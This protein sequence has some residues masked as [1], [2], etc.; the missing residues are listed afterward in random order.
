MPNNKNQQ[1]IGTAANVIDDSDFIKNNIKN[2]D[3]YKDIVNFCKEN[4]IDLDKYKLNPDEN[5]LSVLTRF[6]RDPSLLKEAAY[7][8]SINDI[9]KDIIDKSF[10]SDEQ[11]LLGI[12][13]DDANDDLYTDLDSL[14][15]FVNTISNNDLDSLID[16]IYSQSVFEKERDTLVE[17]INGLDKYEGKYIIS[18]TEVS[19][20]T[21]SE[22]IHNDD[23]RDKVLDGDLNVK[24]GLSAEIGTD[25]TDKTVVIIKDQDGNEVISL[26]TSLD[27]LKD[28]SDF[29]EAIEKSKSEMEPGF[30]KLQEYIKSTD[31]NEKYHELNDKIEKTDPIIID[32]SKDFDKLIDKAKTKAN[33]IEETSNVA[34]NYSH[35]YH[36]NVFAQTAKLLGMITAKNEGMK[37][38]GKYVTAGEMFA[39]GYR[40]ISGFTLGNIVYSALEIA[41]YKYVDKVENRQ[42]LEQYHKNGYVEKKENDKIDQGVTN[43]HVNQEV[44][45]DATKDVSKDVSND[46]NKS[47][48]EK[49]SDTLSSDDKSDI[50]FELKQTDGKTFTIDESTVL[51]SRDGENGYKE[52]FF[53]NDAKGENVS[54]SFFDKDNNLLGKSLFYTNKDGVTNSNIITDKA[55]HVINDGKI[56]VSIF[57]RVENKPATAGF[58]VYDIKNDKYE[59]RDCRFDHY[60]GDNIEIKNFVP[61]INNVDNDTR[62]AL[63]KDYVLP[64]IEIKQSDVEKKIDEISNQ[65]NILEKIQPDDRE[66]GIVDAAIKEKNTD[67]Q[68]LRNSVDINFSNN[69]KL[70]D[71]IDNNIKSHAIINK[72]SKTDFEKNNSDKLKGFEIETIKEKLAVRQKDDKVDFNLANQ[73]ID[74]SSLSDKEKDILKNSIESDI[75]NTDHNIDTNLSN[76]DDSKKE[77]ISEIIADIY[78]TKIDKEEGYESELVEAAKDKVTYESSS[79]ETSEVEITEEPDQIENIQLPPGDGISL[80]DEDK[81]K[82]S[83]ITEKISSDE[84]FDI[85]S[86]IPDSLT[87]LY[88]DYCVDND[89]DDA[90][91]ETYTSFLESISSGD[92]KVSQDE[93]NDLTNLLERDANINQIETVKSELLQE[94]DLVIDQFINDY[95][96]DN[97]SE[98]PELLDTIAALKSNDEIESI[99]SGIPAEDFISSGMELIPENE[100]KEFDVDGRI[101]QLIDGIGQKIV[102]TF[103]V[104]TESKTNMITGTKDSDERIDK[105]NRI[106]TAL[107]DI[108]KETGCVSKT[109]IIVNQS[110]ENRMENSNIGIDKKELETIKEELSEAFVEVCNE[111]YPEDSPIDQDINDVESITNDFETKA[112]ESIAN[113]FIDIYTGFGKLDSNNDNDAKIKEAITNAFKKCSSS[114]GSYSEN[115]LNFIAQISEVGDKINEITQKDTDILNKIDDISQI[116]VSNIENPVEEFKP[117]EIKEAFDIDFDPI[118]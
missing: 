53:K 76:V 31:F 84:K 42:D 10:N 114:G 40:L 94:N 4:N 38:D 74:L 59:I 23:Y 20:G 49:N 77:E 104:D 48:I 56:T 105:F 79:S 61:K 73:R 96:D 11:D 88:V 100:N 93:F 51:R 62:T 18:G 46:D 57:G 111:M 117:E 34:F 1:M 26:D 16:N 52:R 37:F 63:I 35:L 90:K 110:I 112:Q 72:D 15:D 87:P 65:I 12:S 8:E 44:N 108:A 106:K 32:L 58:I 33:K 45:Q 82:I 109:E 69:F 41:I 21:L 64:A 17:N 7:G 68:Q 118:D 107:I 83:V 47:E 99:S 60:A 86:Y 81:E 5:D 39:E 28:E 55:G 19:P 97:I 13:L 71:K 95:F 80:S 75:K 6:S 92:I 103:K 2:Q 98:K 36:R 22:I 24:N 43:E 101:E 29:N 85:N 78:G 14:K 70:T 91:K 3:A 113:T 25:D 89:L 30:S 116:D 54:L 67:I 9:Y 115:R 27:I 66:K 102:E 50:S